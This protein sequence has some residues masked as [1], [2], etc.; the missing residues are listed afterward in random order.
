VIRFRTDSPCI[1]I[2]AELAYSRDLNH[3]SR[4]ASAG[5]DLYQ[6][7]GGDSRYF[8]TAQPGPK[9]KVLEVMLA[10]RQPA[11]MRDWTLYLPLYGGAEKIEIG[12]A[13]NARFE[14]PTPHTTKNPIVFYG[15]SITQG[16]CASRPGNTYASML[17]RAVDA[18]QINLG[19]SGNACGEPAIARAIASLDPAVFV[20]DYDHNAPSVE[21]L[22][23]THEPFFRII[24]ARH[25]ELP[26]IILSRCTYFPSAGDPRRDMIRRTFEHAV[27]AGDKKVWFIDGGTLCGTEDRDACTVDRIHPNDLGFYR[28]YRHILPVLQDAIKSNSPAK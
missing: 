21:A 13:P 26:I 16:A 14:V 20:L 1:A 28:M 10:E 27:A 17:C 5:F 3:M 24:R 2:R 19:F 6:G 12:L 9:Q 8:R 18:P 23:R 15:S 22:E 25:P 7:T 11:K 4:A